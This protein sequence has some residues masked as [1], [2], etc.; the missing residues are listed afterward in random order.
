MATVVI[1]T[2]S[3]ML[4]IRSKITMTGRKLFSS[5]T[6]LMTTNWLSKMT[7]RLKRSKFDKKKPSRLVS[8]RSSKK[9]KK[10]TENSKLQSQLVS[11]TNKKNLTILA[12]GNSFNE[13][14]TSV[15]NNE[16]KKVIKK[17]NKPN[18]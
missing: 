10:I 13:Q 16:Y 14:K 17:Q 18:R 6:S 8:W 5:R 2:R 15:A 3:L 9:G 1:T 11:L 12:N 4:T 7:N